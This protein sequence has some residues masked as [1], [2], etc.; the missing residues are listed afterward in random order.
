MPSYVE[1]W[2]ETKPQGTRDRSLGDDDIREFKRAI[3]ERLATDH[4]M[5]DDEAGSSTIGY[6]KKCTLVEQTAAPSS[7]TN[8]GIVYT[9]EVNNITELF[10]IDSSGSETQLTSGG[11]VLGLGTTAWRTG[12]KILSSNT[13]TPSGWTDQST[14]YADKFIRISSGTPLTT[15]GSD[16]HDHGGSVGATALTTSQQNSMITSLESYTAGGSGFVALAGVSPHLNSNAGTHVHS[17]AAA[18]NIP[19]YVQLKIYS[20]N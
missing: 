2:D 19:A 15:G 1:S 18:N 14:T 4:V 7:V 9:K 3:R 8:A 6:H 13:N 17:V 12:D 20:K 10:F 11:L 16:T 5:L